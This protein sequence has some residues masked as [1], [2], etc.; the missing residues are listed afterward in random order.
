MKIQINS[1]VITPNN[2]KGI[3]TGQQNG[4][5]V[6]KFPNGSIS[7]YPTNKLRVV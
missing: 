5:W 4:Y 7:S 1:T 6:V 3:V 2:I